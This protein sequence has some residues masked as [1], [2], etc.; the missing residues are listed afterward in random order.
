MR[1]TENVTIFCDSIV[2]FNAGAIRDLLSAPV[3]LELEASQVVETLQAVFDD[4]E[5]TTVTYLFNQLGD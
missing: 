4:I 2:W 1:E 3:L 5:E